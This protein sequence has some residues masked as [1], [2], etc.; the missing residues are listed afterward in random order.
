MK[1]LLLNQCFWPDVVA[2][3]QQLTMLARRLSEKG[4][5]VTVISSRRGYNNP[6]LVFPRQ[7]RWQ[8]IDIRRIASLNVGKMSRWQRV[9]NFGSFLVTC[10]VQLLLTPKHDV[11]VALTSPPL[12]SWIGSVFT[13]MKG[14]KLVFWTMDLNP[15]EAVA[16][17]WLKADTFTAKFLARLLKRSL[18]EAQ[19]IVALDRFMKDR[20]AAKGIEPAKIEVIPP[21]LDDGVRFDAAGRQN[22]RAEHDLQAKFVVMY[23]GN[24]SPCNPL[25]TLLE[26]AELVKTHDEIVFL[27]VGGGSGLEQVRRVAGERSLTNIRCLPYQPYDRL[28]ALLSSADL[29][30]VV[31]GDAFKGI[32]HPSK[33]YNILRVGSQFLFIG[34][35]E[36]HVSDLVAAPNKQS[37]GMFA[38]HGEATRI[39]RMILDARERQLERSTRDEFD[40]FSGDRI[41]A[42]FIDVLEQAAAESAVNPEPVE[43]GVPLRKEDLSSTRPA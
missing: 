39:A 16:A 9:V 37:M 32:L 11:V 3:S 24:H 31:M 34:P 21:A 17:G 12:I 18:D 29:H 25:D 5:E 36:S 42:R 22:F 41:Y 23:A 28:S 40:E 27:F 20:I 30:A 10:C 33:I 1:V 6:E 19:T 7:E 43:S 26:A 4:H 35:E 2:T 8:G 15:D 14:G 13:R 38:R